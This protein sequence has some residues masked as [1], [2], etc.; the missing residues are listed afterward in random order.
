MTDNVEVLW[1]Y[2]LGPSVA[3]SLA[4]NSDSPRSLRHLFEMFRV[5]WSTRNLGDVSVGFEENDEA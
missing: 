1:C 5:A 4:S 3:Y 2:W